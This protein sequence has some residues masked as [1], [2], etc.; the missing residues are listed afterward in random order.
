MKRYLFLLEFAKVLMLINT[1]IP[2]KYIPIGRYI[3]NGVIELLSNCWD[4]LKLHYHNVI[5]KDN[6]INTWWFEKDG[7]ITMDNQQPST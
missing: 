7:D 3:S 2:M 4:I 1:F 5:W 6:K